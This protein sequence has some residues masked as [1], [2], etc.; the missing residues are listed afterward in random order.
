MLR[1]IKSLNN[2]KDIGLELGISYDTIEAIEI[3][4][5]ERVCDCKR[6]LL[7]RWLKQE[8]SV[9]K[10]GGPSWEQLV[11]ALRRIGEECVAKQV[12]DDVMRR[13]T[14]EPLQ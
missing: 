6:D 3:H 12:E 5:R 7:A 1:S 11:Q 13:R 10:E 2:W 14:L 8:D 9:L 4:R